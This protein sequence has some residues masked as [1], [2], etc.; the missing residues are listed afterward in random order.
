MKLN[1]SISWTI[2]FLIC[3]TTKIFSFVQNEETLIRPIAITESFS[4]NSIFDLYVDHKGLLFLGT[5]NGLVSYN[6]VFTKTYGF[7]DNLAISVNSIQ[8]DYSNRIWCKNFSDQ[9][10]YW[11]QK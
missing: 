1:K 5:D 9:V 11:S 3:F 8:Q 4:G 7:K 2:F 6:G 10:F